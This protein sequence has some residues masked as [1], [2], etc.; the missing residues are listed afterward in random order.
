MQ[1][2]LL[3]IIFV[4]R[5]TCT[6]LKVNEIIQWDQEIEKIYISDEIGWTWM[7]G[8]FWH[9]TT[10]KIFWEL[11]LF[12][13]IVLLWTDVNIDILFLLSPI[14]DIP[15]VCFSPGKTNKQ[16]KTLFIF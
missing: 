11:L 4:M 8:G 14:P 10:V 12:L 2:I 13:F 7:V 1:Y 5:K 9:T 16:Q 3:L 15:F 6:H